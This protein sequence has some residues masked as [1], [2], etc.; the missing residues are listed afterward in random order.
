[1]KGYAEDAKVQLSDNLTVDIATFP[2]DIRA[3][4]DN[5]TEFDLNMTIHRS[6]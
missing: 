4:D 6:N 5:G 1:M 2:G 3:T